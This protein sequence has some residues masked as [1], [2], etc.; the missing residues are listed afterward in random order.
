[1][2]AIPLTNS[3]NI[4][5]AAA[6]ADITVD[7][8]AQM[9]FDAQYE[10]RKKSQKEWVLDFLEQDEAWWDET[11]AKIARLDKELPKDMPYKERTIKLYGWVAKSLDRHFDIPME[12]DQEF[13]DADAIELLLTNLD[14]YHKIMRWD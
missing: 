1:M 8:L 11:M 14:M 3:G 10:A 2:K 13:A 5:A 6:E 12:T 7:D 4:Q 9:M